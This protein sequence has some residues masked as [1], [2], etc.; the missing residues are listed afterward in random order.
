MSQAGGRLLERALASGT[1]RADPQQL[2]G[3]QAIVLVGGRRA[4]AGSAASLQRALHVPVLVTGKG[5]GDWP[6]EAESERMAQILETQY[7]LQPRWIE[8]DSVTTRE[9]AVFSA[10]IL[11]PQRIHKIVLVT[12]AWHAFRAELWFRHSGFDVA[13]FPAAEA[14]LPLEAAD[15]VPSRGGIGRVR[16]ALHE[17]GGIALYVLSAGLA[18]PACPVSREVAAPRK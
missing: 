15:F 2:G 10:C 4:R 14:T 8:T 12:D 7:G 3:A 5:T 13:S 1:S 11:Q 17:F 16:I 18:S 9:K 6:F